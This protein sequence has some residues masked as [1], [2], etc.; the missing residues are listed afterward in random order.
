MIKSGYKQISILVR[1]CVVVLSTVLVLSACAQKQVDTN[2]SE[3]SGQ[4][5]EL[6]ATSNPRIHSGY[7]E[8]LRFRLFETFNFGS[9]TEINKPDISELLVLQFSAAVEEQLLKR[10]YSKSDEP[11]VLISI[12]VDLKDATIAPKIS[13]TWISGSGVCPSYRFYNGG[14]RAPSSTG[15]MP[16]LCEFKEGSVRVDMEVMKLKRAMWSG[17]SLVR[18]DKGEAK[19]NVISQRT[20]L[21]PIAADTDIMFEN[22]PF[23]VIE[24]AEGRAESP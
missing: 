16:T 13:R 14:P 4:V 19:S 6:L 23:R 5:T 7:E 9:P 10:G 21:G 11:D 22:F 1:G 15:S 3:K 12:S 18:I 8:S 24:Q 17:V 2:G 20:L